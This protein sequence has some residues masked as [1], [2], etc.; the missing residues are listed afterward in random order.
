MP[1][2]TGPKLPH[3]HENNPVH[4]IEGKNFGQDSSL[5]KLFEDAALD[6]A[7][8]DGSTSFGETRSVIPDPENAAAR[9][10]QA[11]GVHPVNHVLALRSD[12][13]E[14]HP[15]LPAELTNMFEKAKLL[16]L[17]HQEQDP[18]PYGRTAHEQSIN[19]GLQFTHDQNLTHRLYRYSDLFINGH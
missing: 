17:A 15:W 5:Q 1:T 4:P 6:A 13:A 16:S 14:A 12:L 3:P 18:L 8:G 11:T 2:D 10:F 7:I 19:L 9:W